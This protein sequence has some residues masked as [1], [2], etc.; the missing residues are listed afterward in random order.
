[1]KKILILFGGSSSEHNISCKSAKSV[2]ENIDQ[3]KFDYKMVG[4]D[5]NHNWYQ[6]CDDLSYLENG[7]WKDANIL[8]ID[9]I[10]S[11]LKEFDVVFP[12]MHGIYGEDGTLQGLLE[13]FHI[14][15]VGCGTLASAI[16]MDKAIS[17]Q[18]FESL[19][20]PQVPYI[21]IDHATKV[22]T[23]LNHITFPV[24]VKPSNGG[25]SIGINKA[26]NKKELVKAI[27]EAKKYDSK[28]IVEQFIVCRELECAVLEKDNNIICS[29][30]GEIKSAN[31]FYDYE[32]KYVNQNSYT[33]IPDDLDNSTIS[34]IQKYAKK[35][36]LNLGCKGLSRIDF[37]YEEKTKH[38]YINEINTLPGF[39]TISMYPKLIEHEHISYSELI[40][41]LIENALKKS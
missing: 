21:V 16:G 5:F 20:I 26:S 4:I 17:K 6:F 15:F 39:T 3:N 37:F 31:E 14:P 34:A 13:Y 24:I 23:I 11:Y 27:Q 2:I 22:Q 8:K 38:I 25:S 9:N 30:P 41:I 19:Q 33:A 7:K 32:A 35:I 12:V 28:I 29:R 1:M 40:T 10:I 18:F 36:F